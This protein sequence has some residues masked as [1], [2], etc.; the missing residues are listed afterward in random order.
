MLAPFHLGRRKQI[1]VKQKGWC[2]AHQLCTTKKGTV[3]GVAKRYS[4]ILADASFLHVLCSQA[5]TTLAK[6]TNQILMQS[7]KGSPNHSSPHH[8][9]K[10]QCFRIG[11]FVVGDAGFGPAKSSTTDL[12]S[13]PFG[14]SGNPPYYGCRTLELVNGVEP[15]TC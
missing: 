12:Q 13:A 14:R 1:F 7:I 5:T 15:S 4:W 10:T 6:R 2:L 11:S 3:N 9:Q 8:K